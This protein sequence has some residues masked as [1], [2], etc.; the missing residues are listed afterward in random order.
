MKDSAGLVIAVSL[1]CPA[2]NS[3]DVTVIDS[4]A[5]NV[6]GPQMLEIAKLSPDLVLPY[7]DTVRIIYRVD[8]ACRKDIAV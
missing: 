7:N 8:E 1:E 4:F 3:C 2:A 6:I 5:R